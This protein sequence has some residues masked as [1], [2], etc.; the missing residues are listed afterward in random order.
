MLL[1]IGIIIAIISSAAGDFFVKQ[2]SAEIEAP[3]LES[4]GGALGL[5]NPRRLLEF[6][7]QSTIFHWKLRVGI[8]LLAIYFGSFILAMHRAPVTLVVPLMSSTHIFSTLIGKYILHEPVTWLRWAGVALIACGT[9][10]LVL[11]RE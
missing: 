4:F 7:R 6:L 2:G 8:A 11:F 1:A 3:P 5:L 9:S 10:L